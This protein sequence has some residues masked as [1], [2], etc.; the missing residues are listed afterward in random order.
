V[1][2]HARLARTSK[3]LGESGVRAVATKAKIEF[4]REVIEPLEAAI[5]ADYDRSSFDDLGA[6]YSIKR[7]PA[8]TARP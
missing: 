6:L 5:S 7:V 4:Y 2:G 3:F 8:V 1:F